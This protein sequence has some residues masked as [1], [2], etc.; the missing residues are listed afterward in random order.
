MAPH[1]H[2]S[3]ISVIS[4]DLLLR[5]VW[6]MAQVHCKLCLRGYPWPPS[7]TLH[8]MSAEAP[9]RGSAGRSLPSLVRR[10][11]ASAHRVAQCTRMDASPRSSDAKRYE[12]HRR[13][14]RSSQLNILL[15][16]QSA[17][18]HM[19]SSPGLNRPDHRRRLRILETALGG[20]S[21]SI[22][23]TSG[24]RSAR[25]AN[26]PRNV[27]LLEQRIKVLEE[28]L[29]SSPAQRR[30]PLRHRHKH[31]QRLPAARRCWLSI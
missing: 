28:N 2:L 27:E 18:E 25:R 31:S 9:S 13:R 24:P 17:G 16:D 29:S 7:I 6:A 8:P 19:H 3:H 22:A 14:L 15:L 20:S 12:F 23:C 4:I 30:R 21:C 11:C 10:K 1:G 5:S 26:R